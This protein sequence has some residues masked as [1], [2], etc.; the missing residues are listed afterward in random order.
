[1]GA[2]HATA[3]VDPAAEL[4]DDVHIGPGVVIGPNVRIAERTVVHAHA[5]IE[6]HTEIGPGSEIFPFATIGLPPQHRGDR[7]ESGR[8]VVGPN[9]VI[10]EHVSIHRGTDRGPGVTTIGADCY[11]MATGHVAHDCRLGANVTMANGVMLG[12]NVDVGDNSFIGGMTAVHQNIRIGRLAMVAGTIGL[13]RHIVPFGNVFPAAH[14]GGVLRGANVIGMRR[15]GFDRDAIRSVNDA[16]VQLFNGSG[17]LA[18]RLPMVEERLGDSKAVAEIVS[19]IRA[20][21]FR[22]LCEADLDH[23]T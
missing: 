5:V 8:L 9:C 17:I 12:G 23:E 19:F 1:M 13:Y 2:V 18:D 3:H 6:G 16:Y 11:L 21:E 7:G 4:A 10:R 20:M 15:N 22:G 14:R